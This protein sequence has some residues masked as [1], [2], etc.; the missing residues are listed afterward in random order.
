[1]DKIIIQNP[2]FGLCL[3]L[4]AFLIGIKIN[5][6]LKHPVFNPLLIGVIIVICFLKITKIDYKIYYEQN[7][8]LNFLLGPATVVL[9]VPLYKNM[10]VL[11]KNLKAVLVGVLVGSIT[12]IFS[13]LSIGVFLGAND[14][15]LLSMAPKAITTP[16]AMEVSHVLGGIPPL[17]AGLVA[18]TG[19]F[20]ACF[21]P[22]ILNF[23]RVKNKVAVGIAIGT[24]TH[25]LGT[26]RAFQEGE[27]Q[28]A[29]SSLSIGLAGLITAFIA[30][31][32]IFIMQKYQII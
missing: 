15:V 6:K 32:I 5:K 8:M 31:Y 13:V 14:E 7:K 29:M 19:I 17:T 20:G 27:V 4:I 21:A 30:P 25:A 23:F 12:S 3:S 2:Y 16:I 26:T 11:K 9:A 18:I 22:E 24:T 1:M 28:G 10:E